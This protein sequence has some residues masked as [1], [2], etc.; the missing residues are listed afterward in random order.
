MQFALRFS[1]LAVIIIGFCF[2]TATAVDR[3]VVAEMITNTGCVPCY[4]ADITLDNIAD[5]YESVLSVIRYHWYYPDASDPYYN[6]NVTENMTRNN[7][8]SNNY[9]P[10]LLIDGSIDGGYTYAGWETRIDQESYE[11][12]PLEIA[13]SGTY[14][15]DVKAGNIDV[16]IIA[17][18]SPGASSLRL[19]IALIEDDIHWNAPN[20]ISVHDQ[21][22]RDMIPSTT[23]QSLTLAQG[24]TLDYSFNFTLNASFVADNCKLVAFVQSDVSPKPILQGA[25]I[26][27][28]E[29]IPSAADDETV[30][31][32][33]ALKQNFPNPFNAQT[34]I[35]FFT[36]GGQVSLDI[37]DLTGALVNTLVAENLSEGQHS[38]IW[39]GFDYSGKPVSSGVYFYRLQDSGGSEMRKMT[40]LK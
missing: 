12:S 29:M 9:S 16:R 5:G 23:G 15:P 7:Y 20:G 2:T 37:Y 30:P 34:R 32:S 31:N 22:F 3:M 8:Y 25:R 1:L 18:D 38:V 35:D 40:L 13:L 21:T 11:M 28:P 36:A 24:D 39:D 19:R 14:S 33:F 26:A 27:V 4:P 6:F 10:H 17:V